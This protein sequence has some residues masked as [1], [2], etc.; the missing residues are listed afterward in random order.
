MKLS[1]VILASFLLVACTE[2][3]PPSVKEDYYGMNY[4][5]CLGKARASVAYTHE[6]MKEETL[7]NA[8]NNCMSEFGWVM[9]GKEVN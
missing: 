7:G 5:E 2:K 4:Q 9:E 1:L 6:S 8:I 3:T